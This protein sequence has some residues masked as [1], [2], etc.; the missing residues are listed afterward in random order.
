MAVVLIGAA[1]LVVVG[2]AVGLMLHSDKR[3]LH[4]VKNLHR[5]D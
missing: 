5:V 4:R 2:T 1:L 3:E